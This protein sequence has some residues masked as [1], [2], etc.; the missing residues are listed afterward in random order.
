MRLIKHHYPDYS[1]D[2]KYKEFG[3]KIK[4]IFNLLKHKKYELVLKL[5]D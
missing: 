5:Y 2:T 3:F 1:S 4:L